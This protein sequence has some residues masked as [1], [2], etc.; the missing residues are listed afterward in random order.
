MIAITLL[1]A[2]LASGADTAPPAPGYKVLEALKLGGDGG[3]D[4]LTVDAESRRVFVS[5]GTHV[6][7][8]D[9]DTGKLVGDIPDT[10]GV[11]GIAIAADLGRGFTSNGRADSVTIFDLATLAPRGQVKTGAN[12]D[13]ILY[14]K[15]SGRVFAFNGRSA[16][17]TAIDAAKGT[18]AGTIALGGKPEAAVADGRGGIYVNVED[19]SEIVSFDAR[20][21]QVRSRWPLKPCE[22]PSGLALDAAHGRLFSV[23]G[24]R[25]MA[26]VDTGSGRVIATLP[27][28]SGVDGAAFDAERALAFASNGEGTL[29]VVHE[30]SPDAFRVVENVPTQPGARTLTLDPKTHRLFLSAAQL[31]PR[32]SPTAEVPRPRPSVVPG[33]FVILVMGK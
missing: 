24:N 25:L 31:G 26:V 10:P 23:C 18:V 11:H 12:P 4:Y 7:V 14:D 19:T 16:D 33:S 9:A 3:W 15:A 28:G 30:D 27:I 2:V 20:T 22:E 21:L 1:L 13:A 29:T 32:P 6:M 8:V 17:A 5:R